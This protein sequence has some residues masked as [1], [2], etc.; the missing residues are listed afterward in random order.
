MDSLSDDCANEWSGLHT[1]VKSQP[2]ILDLFSLLARSKENVC[3]DDVE[4]FLND[5]MLSLGVEIADDN[6]EEIE[7][8]LMLMQE[9]CLEGDFSSIQRLRQQILY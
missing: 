6:I 5:S 2:L 7:E 8:K 9:E 4:D 1:R 3:I